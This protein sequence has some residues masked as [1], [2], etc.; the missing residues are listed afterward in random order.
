MTGGI[1]E[2]LDAIESVRRKRDGED[3]DVG[4]PMM[5][6]EPTGVEDLMRVD[7]R[8]ESRFTE[9]AEDSV[10]DD[11]RLVSGMEL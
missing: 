8:L 11:G 2:P 9:E 1:P 3:C 4:V 7:T 10:G 5:G 6:V